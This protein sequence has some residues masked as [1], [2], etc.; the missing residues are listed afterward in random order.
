MLQR[1]R[2]L[3]VYPLP[4]SML[5]MISTTVAESTISSSTTEE[6]AQDDSNKIDDIISML[7]TNILTFYGTTVQLTSCAEFFQGGFSGNITVMKDSSDETMELLIS[8]IFQVDCQNFSMGPEGAY[9]PSAAFKWE[10]LETKLSCQLIAVQRD[11]AFKTACADFP[12]IV[13]NVRTLK[14]LI[15][16]RRG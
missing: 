6:T 7:K 4:L 2:V 11:T 10:F 12:V 3:I 14:R 13:G 1:W 16:P 8:G 9:M 5:A 15:P